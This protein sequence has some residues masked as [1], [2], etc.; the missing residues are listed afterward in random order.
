M[1]KLNIFHRQPSA[2]NYISN[3]THRTCTT[4]GCAFLRNACLTSFYVHELG[5][6]NGSNTTHL[7]TKPHQYLL[8]HVCPCC[9]ITLPSRILDPTSNRQLPRRAECNISLATNSIT[10]NKTQ[11]T[12]VALKQ[13]RNHRERTRTGI[14]HLPLR[15][16]SSRMILPLAECIDSVDA[17]DGYELSK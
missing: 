13:L 16:S 1:Y 15:V 3:Q 10:K 2:R 4:R 7:N 11:N 14:H 9:R 6:V 17:I 12:P 8:R 5:I